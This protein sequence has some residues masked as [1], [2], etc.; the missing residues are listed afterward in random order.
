[1]VFVATQTVINNTRF[2]VELPVNAWID[3]IYTTI[4]NVCYIHF[5][6]FFKPLTECSLR[7]YLFAKNTIKQNIYNLK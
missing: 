6:I 2:M 4:Q 3:Q 1:M 5:F 7:L